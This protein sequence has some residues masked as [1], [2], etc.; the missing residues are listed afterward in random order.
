MQIEGEKRWIVHAPVLESPLRDQPWSDRR[1][2]VV[3]RAAEEPLLETVLKPGDCLYLPRGFLH[4]AQALGGV[5]TH[6]T[7]GVHSWTRYHLAEQVMTSALRTVAESAEAR[8]SLALGI[9][10]AD[11]HDVNT[12]LEQVRDALVEAVRQLDPEVVAGA[13]Q[14]AAR[15]ASRAAPVGPLR[16]L[17]DADAVNPDH[18]IVL[19]PHLQAALQPAAGGQVL[20][21]RAASL[22]LSEEEVVPVRSLLAQGWAGAADLGIDLARRLILAGVALRA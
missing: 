11:A 20:R 15:G 6:L 21:S 8:R 16:Q 1:S 19:R 5:S 18:R 10:F 3:R 9:S 22:N 2:A 7:I 12:E 4:A 13:M 14:E 17:R